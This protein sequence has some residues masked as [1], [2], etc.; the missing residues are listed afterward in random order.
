MRNFDNNGDAIQP[1]SHYLSANRMVCFLMILCFYA[2]NFPVYSAAQEHDQNTRKYLES[3]RISTPKITW[4][5][6]AFFGFDRSDEI[7]SSIAVD[8]EWEVREGKLWAT[9]GDRSRIIFLCK[10]VGDPVRIEFETTLFANKE[11][12]IGNI[13]VLITTIPDDSFRNGYSFVTAHYFNSCT[14]F[15]KNGKPIARTEYTPVVSGK[16]NL[17]VL[18]FIKGHIR[19]W[20]NGQIILEAVDENPL[21]INSD[22]WVGIQNWATSM[23]VDNFT[24]YCENTK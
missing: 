2:F 21:Q 3:S 11:G 8:G 5:K 20:L 13:S 24:I 17:V 12:R 7:A 16:K 4:G 14:T 15:Y 22:C 6:S 19:Y 9:S 10:N 1:M 23:S 18:D